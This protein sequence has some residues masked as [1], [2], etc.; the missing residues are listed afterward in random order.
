VLSP[1]VRL[2]N[3]AAKAK[4]SL[5]FALTSTFVS[6]NQIGPIPDARTADK[7]ETKRER[8]PSQ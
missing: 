2:E 8:H 5:L 7:A 3:A 4:L 6:V 1:V